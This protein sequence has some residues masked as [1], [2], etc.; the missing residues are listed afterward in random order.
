MKEEFKVTSPNGEYSISF[1]SPKGEKGTI[2]GQDYNLDI[3][4]TSTGFHVLR[5]GMGYDIDVVSVDNISK[6][7]ELRIDSKHYLFNVKDKY[8]ELLERLGMDRAA[9]NKVSEIK[10]PMP[11]LVLD[12]MVKEGDEVVAD[13]PLFILE[14]MKMENVIKS[15]GDSVVKKVEVSKGN[16]VEKN[17][18][19]IS[20]N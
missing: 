11:G 12:I 19:L 9:S 18:I 7:V 10:A 15:P 2:N 1:D 4:E 16:S 8:D 3:V 6:T 20:F 13:Q 5:N 17:Q 14:A